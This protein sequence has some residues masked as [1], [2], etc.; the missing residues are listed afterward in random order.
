MSRSLFDPQRTAAARAQAT[1][2]GGDAPLSVTQ[3][4]ARIDGTLKAGMPQAVRFTGEV[5][6]AM[7]RDVGCGYGLVGHSERRQLFGETD[8][9]MARKFVAAHRYYEKHG[10]R[11]VAP[12]ALPSSFPR[13]A[14][15]DTFSHRAL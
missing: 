11:R 5:S 7:L 12:S 10:F 1:G 6:G 3:L 14:V 2:D 13:M 15:D 4:A 9:L 8:A